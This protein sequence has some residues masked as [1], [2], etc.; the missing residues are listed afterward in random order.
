MPTWHL[1]VSVHGSGHAQNLLWYVERHEPRPVGDTHC[2]FEHG[3]MSAVPAR[4]ISRGQLCAFFHDDFGVVPSER[5]WQSSRSRCGARPR[6][7]RGI[8]FRLVAAPCVRVENVSVFIRPEARWVY[9]GDRGCENEDRNT[10]EA[11]MVE[12]LT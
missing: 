1:H 3:G 11:E 9:D 7:Q 4:W 10:N 8:K 6:R 12:V 5:R 2:P